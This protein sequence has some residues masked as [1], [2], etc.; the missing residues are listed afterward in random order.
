MNKLNENRPGY[1]KTKVGWIP[2][3]WERVKLKE[4]ANINPESITEKTNKDYAFY[5]IDLSAVDEGKIHFPHNKIIFNSAPSRAR[6]ILKKDDILLAT[7]R[8]NL[9]GFAYIN[10]DANDVI[11]ST[12]YAV[13]RIQKGVDSRYL[14]FN[15]FSHE[16]ERYFY[17]C[18]VGSNYPALNNSDVDNLKIPLPPLPEQKKIAEILSAWDLAFEKT[19][20]LTEAKEKRHKWL[21]NE[22][23]NKGS[24]KNGWNNVKLGELFNEVTEKIGEREIPPFSI[25]AGIG[26]VSQKEKWGKD[27]AGKQYQNYVRLQ[28]GEFAYNK[29]NSKKYTC[30]CA[31]LLKD[32]TE[33]AVPNVFISFKRKNKAICSE[34]YEHYFIA[35]HHARELRKYISSSARSDGLLNLNK[36]DFFK[37]LVPYPTADKQKAIANALSTTREEI[38]LLKRLAEKYKEQKRGLMQKLLTG[39]IRVKTD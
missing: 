2:K 36:K 13:I 4:I 28:K 18:V 22:L 15:L 10:F 35:D 17:N 7:V 12:G 5:Y 38:E 21:L 32:H 24:K 20:R 19:E 30:G 34:F 31:Y 6:R 26:F 27:I 9:K 37:I 16:T 1:K 39:N 14:Y 11:C 8:P 3:E 33:I 29:G 25:S 23:I